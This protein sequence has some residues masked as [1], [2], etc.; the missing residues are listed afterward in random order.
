MIDI[1][2][3]SEN[4]VKKVGEEERKKNPHQGQNALLLT[5]KK[6]DCVQSKE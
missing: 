2:M 4:D 1:E 5:L 3:H 6:L